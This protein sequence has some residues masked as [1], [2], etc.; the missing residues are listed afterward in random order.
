MKYW[1]LIADNLNKAGWSSG[2]VSTFDCEGRDI[3][4]ADAHRYG[5]RFV[6]RADEKLTAFVKLEIAT[7]PPS[8]RFASPHRQRIAK[9]PKGIQKR[10]LDTAFH[11]AIE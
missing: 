9:Q 11:A 5:K 7:H 1:E 10:R 6:V 4:V 3:Y 2:C 8:A